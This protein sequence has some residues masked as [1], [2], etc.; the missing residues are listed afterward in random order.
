VYYESRVE[1]IIY[2]VFSVLFGKRYNPLC[3]RPQLT[4]LALMV[5][6]GVFIVIVTRLLLRRPSPFR[7][8]RVAQ[9]I[10]KDA[11]I[12]VLL[13]CTSRILFVLL[14]VLDSVCAILILR[15]L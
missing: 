15:N 10:V 3:T 9:T 11:G 5:D 4:P 12:Y 1:E 14:T 2:T 8:P 13:L 7:I 6:L